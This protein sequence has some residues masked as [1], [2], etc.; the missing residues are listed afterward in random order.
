MRLRRRRRAMVVWSSSSGRAARHGAQ[1]RTRSARPGRIRWWLRT[2]ALL[3]II[4]VMRT[5]RTARKYPRP[6]LSLA[7]TVIAAIGISLPSKAVLISGFLVCLLA[8]F[9]PSE[10]KASRPCSRR[11]SPTR[12][13]GGRRPAR[14]ARSRITRWS[15]IAVAIPTAAERAGVTLNTALRTHTYG[16]LR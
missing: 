7:G 14:P 11:L 15:C 1:E 4:G 5:G 12:I 8:L 16:R 9:M 3:T 2:G 13:T 6:A 10:P